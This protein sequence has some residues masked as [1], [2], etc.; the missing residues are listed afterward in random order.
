LAKKKKELIGNLHDTGLRRRYEAQTSLV[1]KK[2]GKQFR[3]VTIVTVRGKA[4]KTEG[5]FFLQGGMG[6]ESCRRE[7]KRELFLGKE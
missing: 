2:G 3:G 6:N 5:V 1:E 4:E 7:K